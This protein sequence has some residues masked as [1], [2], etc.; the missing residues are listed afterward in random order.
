M[1]TYGLQNQLAQL[2]EQKAEWESLEQSEEVVQVLGPILKSLHK[3][4]ASDFSKN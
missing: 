3:N 1:A 4:K 2:K